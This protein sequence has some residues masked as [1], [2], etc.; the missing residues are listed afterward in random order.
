MIPLN[1]QEIRR[2][3]WKEVIFME[4][5]WYQ[6]Y[7]LSAK[8]RLFLYVLQDNGGEFEGNHDRL[9]DILNTSKNTLL[10]TLKEL[11]ESEL[12]EVERRPGSK[13]PNIYRLKK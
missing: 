9:N 11:E 3:V 4:K 6:Y 8:A 5:K 10:K 2:S 1:G 12:I 13:K 7:E